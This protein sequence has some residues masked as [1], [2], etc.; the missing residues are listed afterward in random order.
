MMGARR[1]PPHVTRLSLLF[2][3][4]CKP[5]VAMTVFVPLDSS[6]RA[7]TSP[8]FLQ[9]SANPTVQL[10]KV[11]KAILKA[12]RVVIVCGRSILLYAP[13]SVEIML[14]STTVGAGISVHA[15]IPDFRS[16]EGLFQTLKRDN[17]KEALA[18]GK[19]LFDASVFH[20][21]N[22]SP[23]TVSICWARSFSSQQQK[24]DMYLRTPLTNRFL[25]S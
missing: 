2:L 14:I 25:F 23:W 11:I 10:E 8:S 13:I 5:A 21:S 17:P 24:L 22:F 4:D 9:V 20:V 12:K 19:D 3:P 16:P 7:P 18:S 15:G 6:V 1:D